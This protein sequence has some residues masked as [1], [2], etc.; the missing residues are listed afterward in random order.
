MALTR[1]GWESPMAAN[2]NTRRV[3]R[4]ADKLIGIESRRNLVPVGPRCDNDACNQ[5][6]SAANGTL[7]GAM[8]RAS[9]ADVSSVT[10]ISIAAC[11]RQE[12]VAGL[13]GIEIEAFGA[14]KRRLGWRWGRPNTQ[15]WRKPVLRPVARAMRH[16]HRIGARA[17]RLQLEVLR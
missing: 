9:L 14:R 13:F 15:K 4:N 8:G 17:T 12:S 10:S 1:T 5:T 6:S 2:L 16:V 11:G 3:K 7:A